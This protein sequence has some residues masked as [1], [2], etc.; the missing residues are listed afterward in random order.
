MSRELHALK[1]IG[2]G[3]DAR[4]DTHESLGRESQSID[5]E[6]LVPDGEY[7]V[8]FLR[9]KKYRAYG[10]KWLW[11]VEF[12][13]ANGPFLG[14]KLPIWFRLPVDGDQMR[15]AHAMS[16]AWVNATGL[17]PPRNLGRFRP[18]RFLSDCILLARVRAVVR[19]SHGV[20]RPRE[21]SY[22]RIDHLISREAGIPPCLRDRSGKSSF[23]YQSK[24]SSKSN[25]K[26]VSKS[27]SGSHRES[28]A[29]AA[30]C[31]ADALAANRARTNK[32]ER[33]R[34]EGDDAT[35]PVSVPSSSFE[36]TEDDF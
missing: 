17:P 2:N 7:E 28:A 20:K 1:R 35:G 22:S 21:A 11:L 24:S 6:A 18:S 23:S 34:V 26:S 16:Q 12:Q 10:G 29:V 15:R 14:S 31:E 36:D 32:T 8:A 5:D 4:T 9:E 33:A 30:R 25:S 19:D 27:Q 13:I 3:Q